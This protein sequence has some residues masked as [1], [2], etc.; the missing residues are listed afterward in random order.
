MRLPDDL[1]WLLW[2]VMAEPPM[3]SYRDLHDGTLR[4]ADVA[5]M[6]DALAARDENRRRAH[7]A[8]EAEAAQRRP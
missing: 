8:A 4:L 6:V 5:Q 3:C 7:R 2:P 1:D